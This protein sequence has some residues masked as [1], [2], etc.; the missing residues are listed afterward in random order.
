MNKV[1]LKLNPYQE[2]NTI[3]LNEQNLS[4]YSELN[5]FMK[6]PFLKWA[7]QF[8]DS[9]EREL[10][11][12]FDLCVRSQNFEFMFLQA[13]AKNFPDCL[14]VERESF[15]LDYS[16]EERQAFLNKVLVDFPVDIETEKVP[17][18]LEKSV[19]MNLGEG[20]QAVS[21][22]EEAFLIIAVSDAAFPEYFQARDTG[23]IALIGE[24]EG[25]EK[26][27]SC[28]LWKMTGDQVLPL[29][30][31]VKYRFYN[32]PY[33]KKVSGV[34]QASADQMDAEQ[35]KNLALMTATDPYVSVCRIP[36]LEMG[37]S[38]QPGFEI[39]PSTAAMPQIR[40][41]VINEAVLQGMG[42]ELNGIKPGTTVVEF[43]KNEEMIPFYRQEVNVY[44][45]NSI[46]KIVLSLHS[47]SMGVEYAQTV[48][49]EFF[50]PD[51]DDI[52]DVVW[53]SSNPQVATVDAGGKVVSHAAGECTIT[54]SGKETSASVHL[55]ILPQIENIELSLEEVACYVGEVIPID[56]KIAPGN[57]YNKEI[58]WWT[59][60]KM[61]AVVETTAT[62][63]FRIR[64]V[65]IGQCTLTCRA[66]EGSAGASVE[67][68]V[69][70]TFNKRRKRKRMAFFS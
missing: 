53:S 60:D 39:I 4:V 22:P 26:I 36:D 18:Y 55:T 59:S 31:A 5:N 28:F 20:F 49:A 61:V 54:L 6:E 27:N 68:F 43:Y 25:L 33:L 38:Y 52:P 64:A 63:D 3:S 35:R 16:M 10:N 66:K 29:L 24:E 67:M 58:G 47:D 57:A 9:V 13:M 11:D 21:D 2:F 40:M 45:N 8:F 14:S 34:L 42:L 37:K 46:K 15:D 1:S 19:F 50:P 32:I 48:G 12:E 44:Q 7:G 41:R 51:A 70:S 69:D 23:I 65:G 30:D 17:V 56:V 62:G